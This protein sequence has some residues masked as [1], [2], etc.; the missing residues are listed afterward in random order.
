MG[1]GGFHGLATDYL[2]DVD[3]INIQPVVKASKTERVKAT[4]DRE[5][6]GGN[7]RD[8]RRAERVYKSRAAHGAEPS[9]ITLSLSLFI[10][11][12]LSLS[13]A[14][15]CNSIQNDASI[16]TTVLPP[17]EILLFYLFSTI[18]ISLSLASAVTSFVDTRNS[19]FTNFLRFCVSSP[20]HEGSTIIETRSIANF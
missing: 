8:G 15:S 3:F 20:R 1:R 13:C 5:R 10:Y 14:V 9:V 19:S 17:G 7:S 12:S 11:L 4:G 18:L 6:W 16:I 2:D